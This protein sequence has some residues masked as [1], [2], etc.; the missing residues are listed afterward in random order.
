MAEAFHL[1]AKE[2]ALL[3]QSESFFSRFGLSLRTRPA[4]HNDDY[5]GLYLLHRG[6]VDAR[7]RCLSICNSLR[8]TEGGEF[9]WVVT[10][11]E[12]LL[13]S[14]KEAC[15]AALLPHDALLD[16]IEEGI[17]LGYPDA[18]ILDWEAHLRIGSPAECSADI[19][20]VH[21]AAAHAPG[22][23]PE[24]SYSRSHADDRAI[25]QTVKLWRHI[26]RTFYD[27]LAYTTLIT[28]SAIDKGRAQLRE[29][30][31]RNRIRWTQL[32]R[33]FRTRADHE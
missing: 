11:T 7:L 25:L 1:E 12:R 8:R 4:S 2:L 17:W 13:A 18:A 27:G 19:L 30:E 9:D 32:R 26:L 24:F 14:L 33:H 3:R 22:A 16:P 31:L 15:Q 23:S 20:S 10:T 21:P 5:G 29:R 6:A 28:T